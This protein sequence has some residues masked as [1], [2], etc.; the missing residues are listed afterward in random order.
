[1]ETEGPGLFFTIIAFI[2]GFSVLV[3]I[4]EW[5][6][7]IVGRLCGVKI[8]TFSI[9]MGKELFGITDKRGTRWKVSAF[10]IGGYVKFFGDASAA[11]NPGDIPDDLS[12]EEKRVCYHFKPLWQRSLIVFAGP[13]VNLIAAALVFGGFVYLRG[14]AIT[15]PIAAS[16]APESA[17]AEA[18]FVAH[19][20]ILEVAGTEIERFSDIAQVV[21]L[22]PGQR[23]SILVD[24]QG[25]R[26][27]LNPV[28]KTEYLEDRFGNR[29]PYGYLGISNQ[30]ETGATP[31]TYVNQNPGVLTSLA[32]GGRQ[33]V[34]TT[35]MMFTTMGQMLLGIRSVKELGGPIR[36]A[37]AIGEAAHISFEYFVWMLAMLSLNL[38]IV[39]LL[40]IPVLDGGHLLFYGLEAIKGS[41]VSKKAQEA[42]FVAGLALMLIF[43][44]LV[45]LNDLQSLAL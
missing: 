17:A 1:M 35:K 25:D 19:D 27:T 39:N 23:L 8:D 29:Y 14:I 41:P 18:G 6:H 10:P 42:G 32:E 30:D 5:G 21:R 31:Y 34:S 3:F 37:N 2:G 7:Y 33:L 38:G 36:I 44:L 22:H 9:G 20:R 16:I 11:S 28:I 15:E 13:A 40:P 45:T 26:V 24:R 4:H 43:M 12:E